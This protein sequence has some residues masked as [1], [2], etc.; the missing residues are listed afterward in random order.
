M[1]QEFTYDYAKYQ[2]YRQE[3][4][5]H[6]DEWIRKIG[7]YEYVKVPYTKEQ[8]KNFE[9]EKRK[10]IEK[11]LELYDELKKFHETI[12]FEDKFILQTARKIAARK[13]NFD[14]W[15]IEYFKEYLAKIKKAEKSVLASSGY[16]L[17]D[18]IEEII[19]AYEGDLEK[20]QAV[21]IEI[22]SPQHRQ[23]IIE[24]IAERK[25]QFSVEGKTIQARVGDFEKLNYLLDY[26]FTDVDPNVCEIPRPEMKPQRQ[27]DDFSFKLQLQRKRAKAKLNLFS[28]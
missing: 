22:K 6:I 28:I 16:T 10:E 17:E 4:I 26:K 1:L 12:P 9:A 18:N 5:D 11:D 8:L 14:T 19:K 7:D 2:E 3:V 20:A 24:E 25:K 13:D 27:D 23:E 21:M 15:K